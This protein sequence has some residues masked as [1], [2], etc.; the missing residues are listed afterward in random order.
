MADFEEYLIQIIYDRLNQAKE[1]HLDGY[2]KEELL[3]LRS[4]ETSRANRYSTRALFL[5]ESIRGVFG[6]KE[7]EY[8]DKRA[9]VVEKF[10]SMSW[11]IIH[12]IQAEL[13]KKEREEE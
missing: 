5:K 2:S 11:D 3:K 13:D 4:Q 12:A 7:K 10:C 8:F 1:H 6:K 9:K